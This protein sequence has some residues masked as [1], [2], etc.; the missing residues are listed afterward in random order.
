MSAQATVEKFSTNVVLSFVRIEDATMILLAQSAVH[1]DSDQAPSS[2]SL[3]YRGKI[4]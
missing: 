2:L 3:I 1:T 4:E